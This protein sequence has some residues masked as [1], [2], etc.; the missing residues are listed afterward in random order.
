MNREGECEDDALLRDNGV[1]GNMSAVVYACTFTLEE[2]QE[3][4]D[5]SSLMGV[6][7]MLLSKCCLF[8]IYGINMMNKKCQFVLTIYHIKVAKLKHI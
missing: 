7:Q 1:L 8:S 5:S 6:H 4:V 2:D 3:G